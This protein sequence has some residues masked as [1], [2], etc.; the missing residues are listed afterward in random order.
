MERFNER[1]VEERKGQPWAHGGGRIG[2]GTRAEKSK[3]Q[4]GV[5]GE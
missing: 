2:K 4:E 1:R 5:R 3:E